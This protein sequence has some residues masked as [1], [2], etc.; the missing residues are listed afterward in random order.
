M[1]T[2]LIM[3]PRFWR[4]I[5]I[6]FL[7][8]MFE[9][10]FSSSQCYLLCGNVMKYGYLKRSCYLGTNEAYRLFIILSGSGWKLNTALLCAQVGVV[11][12]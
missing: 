5:L 6:C 2:P 7:F 3:E 10:F 8:E 1:T 9:C 4:N 12:Y 11:K